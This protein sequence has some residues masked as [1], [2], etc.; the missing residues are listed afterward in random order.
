M[1]TPTVAVFGPSKSVE[2][3]PYGTR[4]RVVEKD[5]ACRP[6]CDESS[7]RNTARPHGCLRDIS[8]QDVLCA[9]QEILA[10]YPDAHVPV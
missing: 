2:T 7:C 10:E 9:A 5:Y 4:S 1:A 6:R 8:V 3:A